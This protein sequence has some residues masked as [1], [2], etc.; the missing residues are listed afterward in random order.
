MTDMP[1]DNLFG[2]LGMAGGSVFLVVV[3][4]GYGVW[5]ITQR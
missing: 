5:R 3:I 1:L 4:V 2:W